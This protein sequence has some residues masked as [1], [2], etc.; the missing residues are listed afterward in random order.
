[1]PQYLLTFRTQVN[2]YVIFNLGTGEKKKR[3]GNAVF[4]HVVLNTGKNLRHIKSNYETDN[5]RHCASVPV[6]VNTGKYLRRI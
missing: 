1:M 3:T 5:L 4:L 2:T 6:F